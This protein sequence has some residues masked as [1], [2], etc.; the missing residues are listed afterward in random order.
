V[1]SDK[2]FVFPY[3]RCGRRHAFLDGRTSN[4]CKLDAALSPMPLAK[5]T[6]GDVNAATPRRTYAGIALLAGAALLAS[7]I[8]TP[9]KAQPAP[10]PQLGPPLIAQACVGCHGQAGAGSGSVPKI[11]GYSRDLFIAQW[12]AFRNKERP[13]TMMDRIAKGYTEADV[14]LLA[15]YF[16]KLKK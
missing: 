7:A 10:D 14:A 12:A 15:D 8:S 1:K 9:S 16:S 5:R 13:A 3:F 6:G 4:G 2:Q 11:A